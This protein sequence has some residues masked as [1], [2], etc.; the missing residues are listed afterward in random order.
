MKANQNWGL[1]DRGK[2]RWR[3]TAGIRQEFETRHAAER[4]KINITRGVRKDPL[5]AYYR[6][7]IA[8]RRL[9]NV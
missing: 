2:K 5:I 1:W 9:P 3:T 7:F 8:P 4:Y 6:A